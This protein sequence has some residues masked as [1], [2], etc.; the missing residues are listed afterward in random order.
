M[1][2]LPT[3]ARGDVYILMVTD[4]FTK[5]VEAFPLHDTVATTLARILVEEVI[6]RYEVPDSI[7]SDQGT[8]S[9]SEVMQAIFS[10]LGMS[11]TRTTAYH[12]MG[13]GQVERFNR[14][15]EAMLA[16]IVK[17]NQWNWNS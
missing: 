1:G 11:C 8:V 6:C 14:T 4:V 12:S 5:W 10:L 9:S 2:P 16:K 3:S 13:N 15:V 17:E 7:H